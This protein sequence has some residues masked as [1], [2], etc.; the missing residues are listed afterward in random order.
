M[1]TSQKDD[2]QFMTHGE[3]DGLVVRLDEVAERAVVA[4]LPAGDARGE[5]HEGGLVAVG[6]HKD[7]R[8]ANNAFA[9][10]TL[11]FADGVEHVSP[12]NFSITK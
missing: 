10:G 6:R 8:V 11:H 5:L 9:I 3:H 2:W 7:E 12:H 1:L 4:T